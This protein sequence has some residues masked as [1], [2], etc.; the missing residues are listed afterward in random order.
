MANVVGQRVR[1]REDPRFLTGK[2]QYVDDLPV[3][4]TLYVTFVR[5][6]WAHA[7]VTSVDVSPAAALEGVQALRA[8]DIELDPIPPPPFIPGGE[9]FP[10]PP[11]ASDRVR[12]AGDIVAV[13]LA[14]TR[15]ASI[16]AAE[17]VFADIEPLPTVTDPAEAVKDETLLFED[18][19]TNV[20]MQQ[21]PEAPGGHLTRRS[22]SGGTAGGAD[23]AVLAVL[24]T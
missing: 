1:R 2:G 3:D 5:S 9:K 16:D 4:G 18:V 13:V 19:G 22:A 12:F 14:P 23:A 24:P 10:R 15:E 11:V 7:R 17:R 8:A 21:R 6:P 20:V